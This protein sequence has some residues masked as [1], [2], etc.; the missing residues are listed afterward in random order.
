[1]TMTENVTMQSWIDVSSHEGKRRTLRTLIKA[2]VVL[3]AL[4][5][6]SDLIWPLPK[7]FQQ[8][9]DQQWEAMPQ[10]RLLIIGVAACLLIGC[11]IAG[12]WKLWNYKSE[13]TFLL[14]I[15]MLVPPFPMTGLWGMATTGTAAYL[16]AL[17]FL[18]VGMLLM[19][20]WTQRDVFEPAPAVSPP[21]H[22]AGE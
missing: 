11:G 8:P 3:T 14:C 5:Y 15:A 2:V 17:G 7:A 9:V 20:C 10:R 16:S 21:L 4:Y 22:E 13:G 18:A 6:A 12:L 19:F 1:M